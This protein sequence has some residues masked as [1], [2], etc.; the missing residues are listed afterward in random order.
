MSRETGLDTKRL[1]IN[2]FYG[3]IAFALNL[4]IS[5]FIT[6]YI[7]ENF[8]ADAY[9][10]IKLATDFASY[11]SLFTIALNSMASR[12]IM[13]RREVGD[14][15]EAQKYY[16]SITVANIILS[17][18]LTIVSA[19]VVVYLE[20][21]IEIPTE[22]VP[23]VK[24]VFAL[25]F[26]N[27]II[28]L[29]FSTWGNCYYLTNRLD[30][31][32]IKTAQSNILRIVFILAAFYILT[33]RLSYV[34]WGTLIASVFLIICNFKYTRVLTPELRFDVHS[35]EFKKVLEVLASGIWNS[36]TKLSQIFSSGLDLL[37]TNKFI[38]ATDMGYLSVAKTIPNLIVAFNSTVANVFSPNLMQ[39]YAK[40]DKENLVSATRTAMRF[41]SLFVAI[42]NA[43]L[44]TMG[45]E[46][47]RL[48]VP[49]EPA[50]LLNILSILTIINS[51]IT[52][53]MQPLYQVFTITNKIKQSSIVMIVYGFLS[54][55]ITFICLNIT[56][57][58]LFAV[59]G[60]SLVGSLVVALAYHVPYSAKYLGVPWYTF[61]PEIGKSIFS[62]MTSCVVGF[63]VNRIY[64]FGGTWLSWFV[65]A[66]VIAVICLGVNVF[67]ILNK[68]E[69][70]TLVEKVMSKVNKLRG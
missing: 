26:V 33:P 13:L 42:P 9:G 37:V 35:F 67:V 54:V 68:D 39:L 22:L 31:N 60:V 52:G 43:I 21:L 56:D 36:I 50:E 2:M 11:A 10:F 5:F 16:S 58:G 49:S 27:L 55:L 47:F 30:I 59:T 40:G 3:I 51:S 61:Y 48:W 20:Y 6:P 62:L 23:E 69:R 19:V 45:V 29:V 65:G 57:W 18:V 24:I 4:F 53:P 38:G 7:T 34:I 25:T 41:M 46:L 15:V 12:F 1:A 63:V 14:V 28:N 44:I 17:V 32:S 64:D 8:G 66:I 70:K